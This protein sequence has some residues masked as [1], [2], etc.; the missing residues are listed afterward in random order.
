MVR[1]FR[2]FDGAIQQVD[3]PQDGCWIALTNPTATE[4]YE[5]SEKFQIEV[6][7]L[8]YN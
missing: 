3:E 8:R 5:L 1:I 2:T 4:I 6:D 7:D